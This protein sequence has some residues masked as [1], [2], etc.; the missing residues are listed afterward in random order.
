MI[1]SGCV[2]KQ[3]QNMVMIPMN[4]DIAA[5]SK[6]LAPPGQVKKMLPKLIARL[7]DN[8]TNTISIWS[9]A[10]PAI[11][12]T[13]VDNSVELGVKFKSDV[14]G[15]VTAI[16]FYKATA[17]TGTHIG[18]L[19]SIT[20]TKLASVSFSGESAS[21]WQ[22]MSLPTPISINSN[23]IYVVSYHC[24]VGHYSLNTNYFAS[25]GVDTPP[26]HALTNG[27]SGG[28]GCYV[29][30]STSTFPTQTYASANYW[31]DL[32][33]SYVIPSPVTNPPVITAGLTNTVGYQGQNKILSVTAMGTSPTY[34]WEDPSGTTTVG[35][36]TYIITNIQSPGN[37]TVTVTN[38]LGSVSST[39]YMSMG[40]T[41]I[42][43]SCISTSKS[44]VT[45]AWC[46]SPTTNNIIAGYKLY[47]GSG[48]ATN[49]IPTIYDT[50]K[51]YCPGVILSNGTNWFRTYTNVINVG[52]VTNA[53]VTNLEA[54][55]TYFFTTTAYD[56][57]A[58]ESDYSGEVSITIT[59]PVINPITN[60]ILGMTCI[61]N[62]YIQLQT[63]LC[64]FALATVMFKTNLMQSAWNIL[65][66]NVAS[67]TYGNF[68]YT[69]NTTA[70]MKFYRLQIQ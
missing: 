63:K 53:T 44:S 27:V 16:R 39:A 32:V 43:T 15:K 28:N 8:T 64:P 55:V 52:N 51:P 57:N 7:G 35:T 19:W 18:N 45:L 69:D 31:V 13:A 62:G 61:G 24:N 58:L 14:A 4:P 66:T 21:G 10:V 48:T 12:S 34:L 70:P 11:I 41:N 23:T 17:N 49:W 33:F 37:Y 54:S 9:N 36:N 30:G 47:V 42:L 67:D 60:A 3:P 46:P 56:T 20:G 2:T 6:P 59:N 68:F 38:G 22:Q 65:A 5:M 26:L 1:V 40:T 25:K 29:Y 50:N